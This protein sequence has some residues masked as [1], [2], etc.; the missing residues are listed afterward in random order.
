MSGILPGRSS[1]VRSSTRAFDLSKRFY[2]ALGFEK[3][4]VTQRP[5]G[6]EQD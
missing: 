2:E 1:L 5:Q 3:V 6:P 4:L